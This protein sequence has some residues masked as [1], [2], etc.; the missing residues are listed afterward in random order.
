[1]DYSRLEDKPSAAMRLMGRF[2]SQAAKE[3]GANRKICAEV[4]RAS[5]KICEWLHS[6]PTNTV[7]EINNRNSSDLF[8]DAAI[9][10][11]DRFEEPDILKTIVNDPKFNPNKRI[12]N[13]YDDGDIH[14][15]AEVINGSCD[16]PEEDAKNFLQQLHARGSKDAHKYLM[17]N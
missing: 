2:V 12:R 6:N 1:M 5:R 8:I 13:V 3:A 4:N 14:S 16:L 11:Q 7:R 15:P 17:A 9:C 10:H